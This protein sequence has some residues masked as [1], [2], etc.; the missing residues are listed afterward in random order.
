M[1]IGAPGW[2]YFPMR[3]TRFERSGGAVRHFVE[4]FAWVPR[5][6]TPF[7]PTGDVPW[8]LLWMPFEVVGSDVFMIGT[9]N[10]LATSDAD[11]PPPVPVHNIARLRM[12]AEGEIE[13][14]IA[15]A[16]PQRGISRPIDPR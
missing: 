6:S 13:W 14:T 2:I 7:V 4:F 9:G 10:P 8:T 15:G 1:T 16:S 11:E 5:S 3:H 12:N